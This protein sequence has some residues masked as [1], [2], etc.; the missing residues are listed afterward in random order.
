MSDTQDKPSSGDRSQAPNIRDVG[1]HAGVSYQTVSRVIN[2]SPNVSDETRGK[3]LA[4]I[5][6]LDFRPNRAARALAR[7]SLNSVTVLSSNTK[8]YGYAATIE[9]I[10]EETRL[11]GLDMV[12]RA[13]D[14]RHAEH[15]RTIIDN[16]ITFI[17]AVI[18]IV[19][20][21]MGAQ[22]LEH[23]PEGIPT[24]AVTQA[25]RE[26]TKPLRPSV[27]IDERDAA[28]EATEYLLSLGHK[29]V[30]HIPI[31][32]WPEKQPR[33]VGWQE[34]LIAAGITPPEMPPPG[35]TTEWGF[36]I[37]TQFARRSDITAVLCG[38]DDMALGFI[39]AMHQA[40][41]DVPGEISV[42][43]FDDIPYAQ[44]FQPPLTTV[45]QD[46]RALGRLSV[47]V[48]TRT[49]GLELPVPTTKV[50]SPKFIVRESAAP[51]PG[52]AADYTHS[53]P[54]GGEQ[55]IQNT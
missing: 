19:F 44:F 40:G 37:G 14:P 53:P 30:H 43:G 13:I 9:G 11:A 42:V 27:W 35:L 46:F 54:A 23:I 29:T 34:A 21:K 26:G 55:K 12:L 15:P 5:E 18:V 33:Q 39:A 8:G 28:Y 10:E 31:P 3:V 16:A 41:R 52:S 49:L 25:P 22:V 36:E 32:A 45:H 7:G 47:A 48:V 24:V 50:L 20:D 4:A 1:Q 51:P 17:G 38:N 2:G 6:A